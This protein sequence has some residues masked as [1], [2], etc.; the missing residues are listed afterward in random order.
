MFSVCGMVDCVLWL[1]QCNNLVLKNAQ[2]YIFGYLETITKPPDVQGNS[3]FYWVISILF[4]TVCNSHYAPYTDAQLQ[5]DWTIVA[6]RMWQ[7]SCVYWWAVRASC[8]CHLYK[9]TNSCIL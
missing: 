1:I 3:E 7:K 4:N 9:L 8:L 2:H 5:E 6:V